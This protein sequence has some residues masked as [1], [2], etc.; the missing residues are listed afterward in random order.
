MQTGL[1]MIDPE[2]HEIMD[3][4]PA[5][6]KLTGTDRNK[7]LGLVGPGALVTTNGN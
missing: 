6:V 4:N 3:V 5:A 7:L 1:V 2:T